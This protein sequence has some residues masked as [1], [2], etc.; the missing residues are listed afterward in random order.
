V[1]EAGLRSMALSCLV[2]GFPAS[3]PS[4]NV[5]RMK[6]REDVILILGSR[7]IGGGLFCRG[8]APRV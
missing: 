2:G 3:S 6:A 4:R 8:G 1:F 5:G 7:R